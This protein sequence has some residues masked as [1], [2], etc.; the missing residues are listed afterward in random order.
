MER[1]GDIKEQ[2]KKLKRIMGWAWG[3]EQRK[4]FEHMK[5][6]K[7]ENAMI[8]GD[9]KYQYHIAADASQHGIGGVVFQLPG[10][11]P[12][13]TTERKHISAMWIVMFISQRL[14]DA[15]SRYLNTEVRR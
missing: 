12:G 14:S 1:R 3:E 9:S 4:S 11:T 7:C 8:G 15:E 5:K 13:T 10:M 2:K 6:S